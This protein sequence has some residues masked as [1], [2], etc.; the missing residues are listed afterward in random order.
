MGGQSSATTSKSMPWAW[1][2]GDWHLANGVPLLG[3]GPWVGN[4]LNL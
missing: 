2:L 3:G 4:R 1:N